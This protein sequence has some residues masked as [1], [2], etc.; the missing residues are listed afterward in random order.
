ME[1]MLSCVR[2]LTG[3]TNT[4]WSPC[5]SAELEES[6]F[7]L[8]LKFRPPKC[9][10]KVFCNSYTEGPEVWIKQ[11][12]SGYLESSHS[13]QLMLDSMTPSSLDAAITP[14]IETVKNFCFT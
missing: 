5:V 4:L 10:L 14:Q 3:V 11:K 13:V 12:G 6:S 9:A 2:F 1:T 8:C 7:C